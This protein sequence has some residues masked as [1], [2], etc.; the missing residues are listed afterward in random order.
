MENIPNSPKTN[1]SYQLFLYREELRKR[2][3]QYLRLSKKK[4]EIT[5]E[6]ITQKVSNLNECTPEDIKTIN[7]ELEFKRK[8]KLEIYRTRKLMNLGMKNVGPNTPSTE[9]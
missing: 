2:N 8:L 1:L 9:L 5:D 7:Q 3:S 4:F 6:L